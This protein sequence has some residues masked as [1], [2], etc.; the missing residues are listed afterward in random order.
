MW[1]DLMGP[2]WQWHLLATVGLV[3]GVFAVIGILERA[4]AAARHEEPAFSDPLLVLWHRYEVGDLTRREFERKKTA[5]A[6]RKPALEIR[7]TRSPAMNGAARAAFNGTA[8]SKRG[9][10]AGGKPNGAVI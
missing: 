4:A 10:A 5:L 6:R 9:A 7:W 8:P 2:G 1:P 3:T